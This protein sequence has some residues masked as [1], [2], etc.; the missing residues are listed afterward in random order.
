MRLALRSKSVGYLTVFFNISRNRAV[1]TLIALVGILKDRNSYLEIRSFSLKLPYILK[2]RRDIV[3]KAF[4]LVRR[5]L[6]FGSQLLLL[7][8]LFSKSDIER[9]D[10]LV[11]RLMSKLFGFKRCR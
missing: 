7:C 10:I 1:F 6:L 3:F 11:S 9:G 5:H 4:R 8:L 2:R